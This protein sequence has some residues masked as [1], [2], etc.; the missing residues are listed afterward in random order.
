MIF[1][2]I[3][4][5]EKEIYSFKHLN[6]GFVIELTQKANTLM[7]D[8][9]FKA[10]KETLIKGLEDIQSAFASIPKLECQLYEELQEDI[11]FLQVCITTDLLQ[12]I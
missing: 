11:Q 8:P 10:F 12:I 4:T 7:F 6:K 2:Y 9:P 3:Y 5:N 1:N